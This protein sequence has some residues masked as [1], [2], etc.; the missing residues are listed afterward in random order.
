MWSGFT[1]LMTVS[2]SQE[3]PQHSPGAYCG[4]VFNTVLVTVAKSKDHSSTPED[5]IVNVV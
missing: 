1:V 2:E 5:C 4:L 3:L